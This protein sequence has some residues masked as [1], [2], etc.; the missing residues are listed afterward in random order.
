MHQPRWLVPIGVGELAAIVGRNH[1]E[2]AVGPLE[3]LMVAIIGA[4]NGAETATA[5]D[6]NELLQGDSLGRDGLARRDLNDP[7]LV[8]VLHPHEV[9]EAAET[10]S[11]GPPAQLDGPQIR[12]MSAVNRQLERRHPLLVRRPRIP[13][14]LETR[15]RFQRCHTSSSHSDPC[16]DH[17]VPRVTSTLTTRPPSSPADSKNSSLLWRVRPY[18]LPLR[19][20]ST[21]ISCRVPT[22]PALISPAMRA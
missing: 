12:R 18:H 19:L 9:E 1:E 3:G 2:R 16:S 15:R 17:D 10:L 20:P 6:V 11:L 7:R 22:S 14:R 13:A 4:P 5:D 8:D 21:S